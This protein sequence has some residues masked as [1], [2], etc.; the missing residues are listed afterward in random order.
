M[1]KVIAEITDSRFNRKLTN[2]YKLS[3]HIGADSLICLVIDSLK[4]PLVLRHWQFEPGEADTL[5]KILAT[6][7]SRD[8]FLRATYG[9]ARVALD[10]ER[11][12]AVP[13]ALFQPGEEATFLYKLT[14][15]LPEDE[16]HS[17]PCAGLKVQAVYALSKRLRPLLREYFPLARVHHLGTAFLMAAHQHSVAQAGAPFVLAELQHRA[18]RLAAVQDGRLL[19]FN[20][21]HVRHARDVLYFTLLAYRE[22]ELDP[23]QVPLWISGQVLEESDA[24]QQLRRYVRQIH[25]TGVP[26][27]LAGSEALAQVPAWFYYSLFHLHLLD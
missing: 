15:P 5:R 22:A 19:F 13:V 7:I 6:A 1:G 24:L 26:A 3:V 21:F 8:P 17:H 10:N 9:E 2:L 18:L 16:L 12:T 14:S 11:F 25:W 23:L 27:F 4:R 20:T